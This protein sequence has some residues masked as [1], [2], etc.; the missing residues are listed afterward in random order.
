MIGL[1]QVTAIPTLMMWRAEVIRHVF[2]IEP[3]KRL[4][5]EN[6]RYYR[7]HIPDGTHLAFVAY[8]DGEPCGCGGVCFSDE[9]PSPDNPTGRCAYLMN[10]YVREPYRHSGV[11]QAIVSRLISEARDRGCGKI[12]LES[13]AEEHRFY[14]TLGF[15]DMPDMMKLR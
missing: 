8:I 3:A 6:R 14:D 12:Y 15:A 7:T 2:G 1:R 11:G 13:T 10:I 5:V 9:L 4:L